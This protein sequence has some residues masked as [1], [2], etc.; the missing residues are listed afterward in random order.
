MP[1]RLSDPSAAVKEWKCELKPQS[2]NAQQDVDHPHRG[3][4]TGASA[5]AQNQDARSPAA[6]GGDTGSVATEA[7]CSLPRDPA[8]LPPG[9]FL[10]CEPKSQTQV[11]AATCF[12]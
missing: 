2:D 10:R 8:L 1:E 11:S 9:K 3:G 7:G 4:A 6:G 12:I 5:A